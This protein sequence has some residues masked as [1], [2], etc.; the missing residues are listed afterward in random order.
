M[1]P[2]F[3]ASTPDLQLP[4][5]VWSILTIPFTPYKLAK[6]SFWHTQHLWRSV[7]CPLSSFLCNTAILSASVIF[8]WFMTPGIKENTKIRKISVYSIKESYT[9]LVKNNNSAWLLE[10][11]WGIC[12]ERRGR[13]ISSSGS[14]AGMVS[15]NM[16]GWETKPP[17]HNIVARDGSLGKHPKWAATLR[18]WICTITLSTLSFPLLLPR[19]SLSAVFDHLHT[20]LLVAWWGHVQNQHKGLKAVAI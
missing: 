8:Y 3:L 5:A 14:W 9:G 19:L 13:R 10:A 18:K 7:P 11:P 17:Q 16:W 20:S 4:V 15:G 12:W 2:L 1:L 6:T